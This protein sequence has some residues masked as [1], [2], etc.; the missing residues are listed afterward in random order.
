MKRILQIPLPILVVLFVVP[1]KVIVYLLIL[2]VVYIT[3]NTLKLL[4]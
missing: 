2:D 4:S 3:H 1:T